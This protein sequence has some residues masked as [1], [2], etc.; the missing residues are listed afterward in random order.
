MFLL[1][2]GGKSSAASTMAGLHPKSSAAKKYAVVTGGNKGI[3]LEICRQLAS[4]GISVVLTARNEKRGLEA[5]EKLK[6]SFDISDNIM[7]H[8][9]DVVDSASVDALAGFIKNRI[10]K[11][12]ILVNNA[13]VNGTT[14]SD[15][16]VFGYLCRVMFGRGSTSKSTSTSNRYELAVECLQINYYGTK[17][18]TET[19]LPLLRLSDS[20]R[21]VNVS[22][23]MGK[24]GG[25][26]NKW[27]KGVLGDMDNL[28]EEG[29][30]EV[31]NEFLKDFKEG[32][33]GAKGWPTYW[34]PYCVS[35]AA[36]TAYT[37]LLAK[38]NPGML[39]NAVCP[40]WVRTDLSGGSGTLKPEEG[41]RSAVRLALLP[42][43][44]P[45][46]LFFDRMQVSSF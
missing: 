28:T 30:D 35:K 27:A 36:V 29:I 34:G 9:L 24:L 16:G 17:R 40:G 19:L 46:G 33:D 45:S 43:D 12:D 1:K 41:A 44:G 18:T 39:I 2:L 38:K 26:H 25:I 32:S 8:Q 3:G 42:D 13:G 7:F 21:I 10:G 14:E 22:S 15:T 23:T 4:Q 5:V 31:L 37:R 6:S 11:L 20:P